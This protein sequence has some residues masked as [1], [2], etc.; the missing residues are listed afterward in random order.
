[1]KNFT[2]TEVL[3]NGAGD[4]VRQE[5]IGVQIKLERDSNDLEALD[6]L[7]PGESQAPL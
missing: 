5:A 7:V 1:M 3:E 6:L 2:R 4:V